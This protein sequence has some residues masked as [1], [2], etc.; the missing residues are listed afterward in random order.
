MKKKRIILLILVMGITVS[1]TIFAKSKYDKVQATSEDIKVLDYKES[2]AENESGF[3]IDKYE[4]VQSKAWINDNEVLTLSK[5]G[6][7]KNQD[8]TISKSIEYCSIY[9]LNTKQTKDFKDTNIDEFFGV[10]SDKQ[11]VLYSEP[12]DIPKVE[13]AEWIQAEKSGELYHKNVK[14]LNLSTGEITDLATE[15]N[16]KDAEFTWIEGNKTLVNYYNK[17][18]IIDITGRVIDQASYADNSNTTSNILGADDIK[19]LH[20]GLEGKIYY[21]QHEHGK[22]GS[23]LLSLDVKT[24]EIN[25]IFSGDNIFNAY[26]KGSTIVVEYCKDNGEQNSQGLYENR[27]FGMSILDASGNMLRNIELPKGISASSYT[28]STDGTKVAYIEEP[29]VDADTI[30]TGT[31]KSNQ[32]LKVLDIKTG[33]IKEI[34]NGDE[35]EDKNVQNDYITRQI[36]DQNGNAKEKNSFCKHSISNICWDSSGT[37]LLFT[38]STSVVDNKY[39]AYI[40]SFDCY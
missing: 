2:S 12:R 25:N 3:Q 9:N 35:L 5:K 29:V 30:N 17:W 14:I 39:D 10:S 31:N 32:V 23:K 33:S 16:N 28:L 8:Y 11:Y 4:K 6:E 34:V 38:Y 36:V 18:T 22:V 26:K 15:N 7:I 21:S 19:C 40:V 24:K 13:S 20:N 37:S 1:T 27:I